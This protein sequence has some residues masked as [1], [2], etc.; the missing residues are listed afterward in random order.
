MIDDHADPGPDPLSGRD[1]HPREQIDLWP[2]H[3]AR[4]ELLEEIVSQA[5][6][7]ES[8]ARTARS[9]VLL[10]VVGIAAALALVA[11]GAW[12]VTSGDSDDG[13]R[14]DDQVAASSDDAAP[15]D[16]ATDP[17]TAPSAEATTE[18][19]AD[20]TTEPRRRN[21]DRHRGVRIGNVRTLRECLAD[22]GPLDRKGGPTRL[23]RLVVRSKHKWKLYIVRDGR[24]TVAVDSD[25]KWIRVLPEKPR[26][27]H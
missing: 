1:P 2:L 13:G 23:D 15:T 12:A 16:V 27:R 10:T 19:T 24:R 22:V 9:R 11:G 17:S 4:Q 20:R 26:Q 21:G 18:A 7:G 6:P 25:C 14:N 3:D 5:G 8:P